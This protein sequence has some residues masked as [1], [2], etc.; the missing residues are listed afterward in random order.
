VAPAP[1]EI[2]IVLDRIPPNVSGT[3][4][5]GSATIE[6]AFVTVRKGSEVI[7]RTITDSDGKYETYLPPLPPDESY[8]IRITI[9]EGQLVSSIVEPVTPSGSM[10]IQDFD[11]ASVT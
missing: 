10:Q 4:R 6:G 3:V 1:C 5:R 11:F 7:A 9:V 8:D 2:E